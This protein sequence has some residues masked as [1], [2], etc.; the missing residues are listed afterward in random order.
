MALDVQPDPMNILAHVQKAIFLLQ[1]TLA[2]FLLF[3]TWQYSSFLAAALFVAT[4]L[5]YS[6]VL[7]GQFAALRWPN[8]DDRIPTPGLKRLVR[9]WG[10]EVVAAARVFFWW[11]PF[12]SGA[13]PDCLNAS[14]RGVVLVHGF[15]CNRGVWSPWLAELEHRNAPYIALNLEPV[16]GSIDQYVDLLDQSIRCMNRVTGLPSLIVCHSMG[17]LVARAW[18]RKFKD[19]GL[20]HHVVTI[21]TPHEGTRLAKRIWHPSAM[22]NAS[23]MRRGSPWLSQMAQSETS[24]MRQ[25]ITC[26]YSDCDNIVT[27]ASSA[28]LEGADNRSALGLPHVAMALD[29]RIM[30]ESLA[31]R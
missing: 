14:G 17:G 23:Q 11:Q 26:Y 1:L 18:M 21:G 3:A 22:V 24:T 31:M 10:M 6:V 19:S 25:Q 7:A 20:I 12:R 9:A 16:F 27:P 13:H 28:T 5:I 30:R 8:L 2:T 29:S 15:L 4:L